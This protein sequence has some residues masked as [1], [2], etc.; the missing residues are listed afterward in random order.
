M[1]NKEKMP[2]KRRQNEIQPLTGLPIMH[3]WHY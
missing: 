1:R 2:G 3:R